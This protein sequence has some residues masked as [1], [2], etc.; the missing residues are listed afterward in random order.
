MTN[1]DRED[2]QVLEQ[3]GVLEEGMFIPILE[4]QED[5]YLSIWIDAERCVPEEPPV[6]SG[7]SYTVEAGIL[8]YRVDTREEGLIRKDENP[9]SYAI[10][11][12]YI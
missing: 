2:V 10:I 9:E 3:E 4:R 1:L 7:I 12:E 5:S 11:D 6:T 8:V